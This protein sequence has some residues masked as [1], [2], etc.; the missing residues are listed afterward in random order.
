[1]GIGRRAFLKAFGA[2]IAAHAAS[3]LQAVVLG[4]ETYINRSLGVAF[5]RPPGWEFVT[6]R[7]F[8]ALKDAQVL[9]DGPL[10]EMLLSGVDPF[11]VMTRPAPDG[12]PL[13]PSMT[14][15]AE[16]F[17]FEQDETLETAPRLVAR[18]MAQALEDYAFLGQGEIHLVSGVES[19]EYRSRFRYVT[20]ELSA[21]TRHRSV[22]AQRGGA[23]FTFNF[24]DYPAQGIDGQADFDAIVAS[25]AYA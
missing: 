8:P 18:A 10:S 1:M 7:E 2:T 14:A 12:A 4:G 23:M 24:F 22:I 5:R 3:P 9:G 17:G 13:A 19:I 6:A 25:I 11:A 21:V 15:Y 20:A 16:A